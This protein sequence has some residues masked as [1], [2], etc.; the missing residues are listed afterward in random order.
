M[1]CKLTTFK[2]NKK[3]FYGFVRSKQKVRQR[4]T[5]L[6]TRQYTVTDTDE[7][8]AGEISDFFSF[9]FVRE[10]SGPVPEM[11]VSNDTIKEPDTKLTDITVDQEMVRK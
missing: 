5:Q 2:G 3:A 8:A 6:K 10:G 7:E 1:N 9:V 4:I 11:E